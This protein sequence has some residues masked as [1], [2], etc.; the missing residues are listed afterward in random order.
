M[1]HKLDVSVELTRT[2]AFVADVGEAI[3]GSWPAARTICY[4]HLGDGN[5]H[6]NVLGPD[7]DDERVDEVV[8]RRVAAFG[9]SIAAEHGIGVAKTRWLGLTRSEAEIELMRT[10]KAALD[11]TGIL[12]YGRVL[13][14]DRRT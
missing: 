4:G 8:L 3:A 12:G 6:V 13:A 5:V 14:P 1:P 2:A 7:P 11:P 9:G 10:L